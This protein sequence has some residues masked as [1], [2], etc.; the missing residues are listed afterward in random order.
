MC[1]SWVS[2]SGVLGRPLVPAQAC[3]TWR[4]RL[5][6]VESAG[7][8]FTTL[9]CTKTFGSPS[10]RSRTELDFHDRRG[11]HST[12]PLV[13]VELVDGTEYLSCLYRGPTPYAGRRS[14]SGSPVLGDHTLATPRAYQ[15]ILELLRLSSPSRPSSSA[16]HSR[17]HMSNRERW[18][19]RSTSRD[20]AADSP[21]T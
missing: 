19:Q 1:S 8:L 7:R 18:P 5:S 15:Y 2:E 17:Y 13:P 16:V 4:W 21:T 6:T 20:T 3:L 12:L 14:S 11:G 9:L 10:G